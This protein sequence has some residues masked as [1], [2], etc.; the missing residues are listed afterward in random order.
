MSKII[1]SMKK[2]G[3]Y[4]SYVNAIAGTAVLL[5][6]SAAPIYLNIAADYAN[7]VMSMGTLLM[8]VYATFLLWPTF[9]KQKR[10]ENLCI[11]AKEALETTVYVEESIKKLW[12]IQKN[13]LG[14]TSRYYEREHINVQFEV[15][16]YLN[17]LRNT[18]LLLRKDRELMPK[19]EVSELRLWIETLEKVLNSQYQSPTSYISID[20]LSECDLLHKDSFNIVQLDELKKVL[21]DIYEISE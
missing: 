9:I 15:S 18:L 12:F 2:F 13:N 5:V 7:V 11:N 3:A 1:I 10:T 14:S 17:K 16:F 8:A 21:R 6:I 4:Q 20:L 19:E